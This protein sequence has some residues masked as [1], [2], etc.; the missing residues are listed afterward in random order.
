[1]NTQIPK[2]E[3]S[4]IAKA[5][6]Q[7]SNQLFVTRVLGLSGYDAGPSWSIKTVANV[8]S[9][10]VGYTYSCSTT[11]NFAVDPAICETNC[12][13]TG[14]SEISVAFTGCSNFISQ[15]SFQGMFPD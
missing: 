7:Q 14:T 8:D 13:I 9:S 12:I 15:L 4:Y 3:M 5:Y 11:P 2:Y 6:L 1:V 10:T